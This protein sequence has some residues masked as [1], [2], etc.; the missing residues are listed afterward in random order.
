MLNV[1]EHLR[2]ISTTILRCLYVRLYGVTLPGS[3]DVSTVNPT[4]RLYQKD[5]T[6]INSERRPMLMT[7][8]GQ[9][10]QAIDPNPKTKG[11]T[12]SQIFEH[13][14]NRPGLRE[15]FSEVAHLID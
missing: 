1:R 12:L 11:G 7:D 10:R 14:R 4:G 2:S 15:D 9:A 6:D 8:E 3:G 5:S 13:E